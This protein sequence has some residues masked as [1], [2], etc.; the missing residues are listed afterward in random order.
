[1]STTSLFD[2]PPPNPEAEAHARRRKRMA[3]VAVIVLL[4]IG[5]FL[6]WN[7]F[8]PE[9]RAVDKFFTA[10]EQKDFAK[11]YGIW[12]ADTDW[13]QHPD[14]YKEYPFGQFQLDWGP[15]GQY[16]YIT[17]HDIRGAVA[18]SS[19]G[20]ASSGVIVAVRVN[21]IADANKLACLWVEKSSKT[22]NYSPRDCRAQ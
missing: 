16:G 15:T 22:I 3:V 8:W 13:Q 6:Y 17:K 9:E 1:M 7:R 18:P 2:A 20:G 14:K 10:I 12:R 11:A 19:S 21:G 5:G 4:I